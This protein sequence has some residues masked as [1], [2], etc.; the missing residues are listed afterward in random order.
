LCGIVLKGWK[1][2]ATVRSLEKIKSLPEEIET[3]ETCPIGPDT[4]RRKLSIMLTICFNLFM[5]HKKWIN[6]AS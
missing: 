1:I 5:M 6:C 3:I 2:H 4:E